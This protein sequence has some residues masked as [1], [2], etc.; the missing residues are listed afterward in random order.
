MAVFVL[1]SRVIVIEPAVA[2]FKV[3]VDEEATIEFCPGALI[4]LNESLV[5]HRRFEQSS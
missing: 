5:S 1:E 4:V 2:R 3:S